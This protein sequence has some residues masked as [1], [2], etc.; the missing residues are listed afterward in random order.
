MILDRRNLMNLLEKDDFLSDLSAE[1][2]KLMEKAEEY[3]IALSTFPDQILWTL[4]DYPELHSQI[5]EAFHHSK[6]YSG[7]EVV[8]DQLYTASYRL[9][10]K[11]DYVIFRN[12]YQDT[13]SSLLSEKVASEENLA[14]LLEKG[15][16]IFTPTT[17]QEYQHHLNELR[18]IYETF[19]Q[20]ILAP[21][22]QLNDLILQGDKLFEFQRTT[23]PSGFK[24]AFQTISN[25]LGKQKAIFEE[26]SSLAKSLPTE[27]DVQGIKNDTNIAVWLI[28]NQQHISQVGY[29]AH[30]LAFNTNQLQVQVEKLLEDQIDLYDLITVVQS[31]EYEDEY[32]SLKSISSELK[33]LP[34]V[35]SEEITELEVKQEEG[36]GNY[37]KEIEQ[38]TTYWSMF[39]KLIH[40]VQNETSQFQ[41]NIYLLLQNLVACAKR[42]H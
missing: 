10:S 13:L 15:Q 22:F 21:F 11:V 23:I 6:L 28:N 31:G 4:E 14:M 8:I 27:S 37:S 20:N 12:L 24:V 32:T 16:K 26:I 38:L 36:A 30:S 29:V 19:Q 18:G 34:S 25:D 3:L 7:E 1:L 9:N 2:S 41:H 39:D 33:L 35:F 5:E 17:M 42:E 40:L